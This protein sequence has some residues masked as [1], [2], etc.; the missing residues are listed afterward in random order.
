MAVRGLIAVHKL[1]YFE[2]LIG[3]LRRKF[4]FTDAP[5]QLLVSLNKVGRRTAALSG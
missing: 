1:V 5:A 4:L 3:G 2:V